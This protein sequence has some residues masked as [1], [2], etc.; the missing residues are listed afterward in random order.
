MRALYFDAFSG[1]SGDMAVSALLALG[2]DLAQL[3]R[4]LGGL[5]VGGYRLRSSDREVNGIRARRFEVEV[6]PT[7]GHAAQHMGAGVIGHEH[8]A[9]RDIRA[10]LEASSLRLAVKEKAL[11]IF[12]RLAEAEGRVHGLSADDVTFHELGAVDSIVDVVATAIGLVEL[13][14]E[15]VY[16]SVLPLGSG[17]IESQHGII[18][19]PAP[20]T[21]ELLKGFPVRFGDGT[22]E[23]VTPTGAAIVAALATPDEILPTMHVEA[24]GYGAG[25]RPLNDRPNLLRALLGQAANVCASDEMVVLETNIDDSSPEIYDFVMDRL[26]AAGAR[27]V[28]L[29]PVQMKKNRP[30]T[31]LR[32]L[33][34]PTSRDALAGIILRETSAIGVRFSTVQR[35]LLPRE[36][37]TAETEFGPV[38]VKRSRAPDGSVNLAPEYDAC[39]RL[40][41]QRAVPLKVVYQAA[42]AAARQLK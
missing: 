20:A 30:G 5:P 18:P 27:D 32:V 41:H 40:A 35:L 39:K 28:W 4:D 15:R 36:Q 25:A 34:E 9:F 23:M 14:V 37:L 3:Q 16:V 26:F 7:P 42:V 11:A 33:A 6:I 21:V 31:L 13:G 17:T 29:T 38:L 22:G 10:M 8:R 1:I 24:V 12:T 19:I 2:V